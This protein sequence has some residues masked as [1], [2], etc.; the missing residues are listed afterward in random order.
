MKKLHRA[1]TF[2]D[3]HFGRKSNSRQH[4]QDCVNFVRWFCERVKKIDDIDHVIFSG[5]WY[6]SRSAI[7]VETLTYS[8]QAAKL[9]NDLHLPVYFILGNHDLYYKHT[10][11]VYSVI[12]FH[13]FNNFTVIVDPLYDKNVGDGTL[14]CPYLFHNEYDKITNYLKVPV[15]WGHFEFKGFTITGYNIK[16]LSGP[17]HHRFEGPK[18]I[19]SGHFHRRQIQDNIV[20]IGNTFP[21]DFSD[22]GDNKR[23][24]LIY[25]YITNNLKF[26]DWKDCPMYQKIT[27]S[28]IM[29]NSAKII[30]YARIKCIVDT[31]EVSYDDQ[32]ELRKALIKDLHLRELTFEEIDMEDALTNTAIEDQTTVLGTNDQ[33]IEM[34]KGISVEQIDNQKLTDIYISL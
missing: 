32:I 30:P 33:V 2:T 16:L 12:S 8:Y 15:W 34:L 7:D 20:Y 24:M 31:T 19:I 3:I 17:D 4:N 5:D 26:I 29:N 27:L 18:H 28:S 10:R 14:F 23:G 6:E 13:E 1:A 11:E 22:A 9:I 25:D 21:M